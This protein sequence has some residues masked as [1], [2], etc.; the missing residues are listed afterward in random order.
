MSLPMSS[1][2]QSKC[3]E[4]LSSSSDSAL[5][6]NSFESSQPWMIFS[7]VASTRKQC[8]QSVFLNS[9]MHRFWLRTAQQSGM[10]NSRLVC[11]TEQYRVA[12]L[13][14]FNSL[15]I[16]VDVY[17]CDRGESAITQFLAMEKRAVYEV[18]CFCNV[19]YTTTTLHNALDTVIVFGPLWHWNCF[20]GF[21]AMI[22]EFNAFSV[23]KH[24]IR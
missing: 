22:I 2:S 7:T 9:M 18:T 1:L 21:T 16:T 19:H 13:F 3:W 23:F 4:A 10:V 24:D 12:G 15:H 20:N 14:T 11:C 6:G 8:V 5:A 17:L